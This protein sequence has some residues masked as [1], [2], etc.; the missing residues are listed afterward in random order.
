MVPGLWERRQIL[1]DVIQMTFKCS[2]KCIGKVAAKG[3]LNREEACYDAAIKDKNERAAKRAKK[4][5]KITQKYL[6]LMEEWPPAMD[7]AIKP[8]LIIAGIK[9]NTKQTTIKTQVKRVMETRICPISGE[10]L[11][12]HGVTE[13]IIRYLI[14]KYDHKPFLQEKRFRLTPAA[15]NSIKYAIVLCREKPDAKKFLESLLVV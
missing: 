12:A 13:R 1:E 15:I 7:L 14:A 8:A 2:D 10:P 9:D 3:R 6:D 11:G 5:M 4:K